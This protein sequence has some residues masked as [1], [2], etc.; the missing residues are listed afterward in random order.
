MSKVMLKGSKKKEKKK[1]ENYKFMKAV[2]IA[3]TEHWKWMML[4]MNERKLDD[5]KGAQSTRKNKNF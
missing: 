2:F 1:H 4:K 5:E 3:S